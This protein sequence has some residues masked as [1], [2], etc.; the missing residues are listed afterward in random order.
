MKQT[1]RQP[2]WRPEGKRTIESLSK[3]VLH[4]G[5]LQFADD[6]VMTLLRDRESKEAMFAIGHRYDDGLTRYQHAVLDCR[7]S[8]PNWQ[9]ISNSSINLKSNKLWVATAI[10]AAGQLWQAAIDK[11]WI[12]AGDEF[13][14]A[15]GKPAIVDLEQHMIGLVVDSDTIIVLRRYPNGGKATIPGVVIGSP[16]SNGQMWW[17]PLVL[18]CRGGSAEWLQHCR[19]TAMLLWEKGKEDLWNDGQPLVRKDESFEKAAM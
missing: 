10:K 11:G 15:L 3:S 6:D 13:H 8:G 2:T 18:S 19:Y 14:R 4:F 5:V 17:Q 1:P 9:H 12:G 7:Y 16:L